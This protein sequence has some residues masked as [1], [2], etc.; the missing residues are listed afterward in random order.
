MMDGKLKPETTRRTSET[1]PT[2]AAFAEVV[3][4][5]A[6][7]SDAASRLQEIEAEAN[8]A[9]LEMIDEFKEEYAQCQAA[10]AKVEAALETHCRSHK[11]DWFA[12]QKSIKTPY[13]KV[14]FREGAS[15]FVRDDEA[16]VRLIK[17]VHGEAGQ[18]FLRTVEVPDLEALE[19]LDDEEL[20]AVL[21]RR[22]RKDVFSFTPAK[23]EFGK[24][25]QEAAQKN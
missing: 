3:N 4:L 7:G 1:L 11:A 22:V 24:V 20:K 2:D 25:A 15:L 18:S 5:M 9:L 17:A 16:T 12:K 8:A 23:I 6:L 13:G 21:V 10:V 19:K 14:A